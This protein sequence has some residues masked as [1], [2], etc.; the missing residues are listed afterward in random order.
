MGTGGRFALLNVSL[1]G[2]KE[3]CLDGL[4]RDNGQKKRSI[5]RESVHDN[6]NQSSSCWV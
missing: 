5:V 4:S 3:Q 2:V 6:A 1:L